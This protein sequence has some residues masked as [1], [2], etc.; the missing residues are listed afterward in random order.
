[1]KW[2]ELFLSTGS[3]TS[4]DV[5]DMRRLQI[6]GLML[7]IFTVHDGVVSLLP[8]RETRRYSYGYGCRQRR[9]NRASTVPAV[10]RLD[11]LLSPNEFRTKRSL[12]LSS[13]RE[14]SSS[15]SG[16]EGGSALD[17]ENEKDDEQP[18]GNNF[19]RNERWLEDAT[20]KLLDLSNLPLGSL[21][22][23]DVV[24]LTS[25]MIAWSRRMSLEGAMVVE[26]LL[27]RIVDDMRAGNRDVHVSTRMYT[28]AIEAWGKS[29]VTAGAERAQN[30]HDAMI[31]TY[32]QTKNPLIKPTTKSY[33]TLIL[34]WAK[35]KNPSALP[36]AEKTLRNM[37]T[38]SIATRSAQPDAVTCG[39]MLD[40]Y[41]RKNS[42]AS[43]AK[44][45]TLV[46]SMSGLKVRK[47]NY[48]YSAL[49]DVYLRSG[50]KDAAKKT[51]AVLEKMLGEYSIGNNVL[52][53]NVANFNNVLCAYSRTPSKHSAQRAVEML[54]RIEM[55][56]EEGG[57]DVDPDRLS[58][59]LA[60][61]ACSRCPNHTFGANL[62]EPLLR[63]MEERSKTE[64]KRREELSIAAPP[65]VSLD[66]E[67]F[68]VVLTA[69]SKSRDSDAVD[70]IFGI[71]SRMEEYADKG[72]EHLRPSTRS[73]NTALNALSYEKNKD[74]AR[75]AEQTLDHMLQL[76]AN[77]VPNI[78]PDA[79]CY[80]A[81]LRCY[82]GLSTPEAAQRGNDILLR[83]EELYEEK[84]LDAPPDTFH[85]TIV[86]S[87]WSLSRS[88]NAPE[89][90]VEI[91]SRMKEKDKEGW[92]RVTP[93][94]RTYN[95]VLGE[96]SIIKSTAR[97]MCSNFV[98]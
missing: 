96:C 90:C 60:I 7:W 3:N 91:L 2:N 27:K 97:T 67:C 47:N 18:R 76:H 12:R 83:M 42:D 10:Q 92:P 20:D 84:I 70:R 89:K 23:D 87:T 72:Q 30:I 80:T 41:A 5:P 48:V 19:A 28:I 38:E 11:P 34:A 88:K 73:L 14:N 63:R 9:Y 57:Y 59:F 74:A 66:I 29:D 78:K 33:N 45:E 13:I 1:M 26:R 64:A 68:N 61:L 53:P 51:M 6:W 62:A 37:L 56:K 50:R 49:Q 21:T 81:L 52:R 8:T 4:F 16:L 32:G 71:I 77:G 43:I 94:I 46:R 54:N 15:I 44:A 39:T 31:Q 36:A 98:I 17:T 40:L 85:Y 69:L 93:N 95:A 82:Q 55:P 58:Y 86:C 79:F 22:E 25:L 35:S 75:R 65:L 24:S